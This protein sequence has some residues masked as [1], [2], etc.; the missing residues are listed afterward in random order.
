MPGLAISR[1]VLDVSQV[2]FP[3]RDPMIALNRW[4]NFPCL[5]PFIP[6]PSADRLSYGGL[7]IPEEKRA[8]P[9]AKSPKTTNPG[10]FPSLAS[11]FVSGDS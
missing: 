6:Q 3:S 9:N 4:L 7:F 11:I 5:V 10:I 2:S 8:G 1:E